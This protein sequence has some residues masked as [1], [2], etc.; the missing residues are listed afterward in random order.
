MRQDVRCPRHRVRG[1]SRASEQQ[2]ARARHHP[3]EW[4][5]S[6]TRKSLP[7]AMITGSPIIGL[8]IILCPTVRANYRLRI[9]EMP[10]RGLATP[11]RKNSRSPRERS[12]R[13]RSRETDAVFSSELRWSTQIPG[14]TARGAASGRLGRLRCRAGQ[15]CRRHPPIT[16]VVPPG[17]MMGVFDGCQRLPVG[18][19]QPNGGCLAT[20]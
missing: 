12:N 1:E 3:S 8:G 9:T 2:S 16:A 14:A 11:G 18:V 10:W 13:F 5:R 17:Q 20:C 15:N 7:K 19:C 4:I 6:R